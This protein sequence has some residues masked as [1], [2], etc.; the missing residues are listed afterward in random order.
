MRDLASPPQE[1]S[2]V[3][4]RSGALVVRRL[5]STSP[6]GKQLGSV[7]PFWDTLKFEESGFEE[8]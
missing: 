8:R 7:L 1:G 5:R 2:S 6:F 4:L 3:A